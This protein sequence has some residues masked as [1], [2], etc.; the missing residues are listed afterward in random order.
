MKHKLKKSLRRA[1]PYLWY[2]FLA[3]GFVF[4]TASI[5]V[6][7]NPTLLDVFLGFV[8]GSVLTLEFA[9]YFHR[10]D[11]NTAIGIINAYA[12]LAAFALEQNRGVEPE[13]D[14][15]PAEMH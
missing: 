3:F 7:D 8:W 11:L 2:G 6:K 10:R 4:T 14:L 13:P 12:A 15:D 9:G 1:L 5:V